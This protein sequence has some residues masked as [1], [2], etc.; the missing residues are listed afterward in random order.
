MQYM[1]EA[2]SIL[3]STTQ[4]FWECGGHGPHGKPAYGVRAQKEL[5]SLL[6]ARQIALATA[7]FAMYR[8]AFI[9]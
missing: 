9:M 3:F 4:Y 8:K 2:L 6:D 7:D 5:L 1:D